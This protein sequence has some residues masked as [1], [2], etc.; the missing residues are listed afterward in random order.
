VTDERSDVARSGHLGHGFFDAWRLCF[1]VGVEHIVIL[2]RQPREDF[3]QSRLG[4]TMAENKDVLRI[5]RY[6]FEQIGEIHIVG[7]FLAVFFQV[8]LFLS[9]NPA[10]IF[11]AGISSFHPY[12]ARTAE[13]RS[14]WAF[15][16]D[17]E[18][19]AFPDVGVVVV[20]ALFRGAHLEAEA[21]AGRVR[22]DRGRVA[23]QVAEVDEMLLG[24][25]LLLEFGVSPFGD[26][27]GRGHRYGGRV[28]GA[29]RGVEAMRRESAVPSAGARR[30]PHSA[31]RI[32]PGGSKLPHS[33]PVVP[34]GAV[35][36]CRFSIGI[37]RSRKRG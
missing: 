23:D 28:V 12:A 8:P 6:L 29:R 37:Q 13:S 26:E 19:A 34:L 36:P 11:S 32:P 33:G 35:G 20:T 4:G 22:L 21:F 15:V 25:G 1:L 7:D 17:G 5:D 3:P 31:S 9:N 2:R 30:P 10:R 24:G 14:A 27:G 18:V 16:F